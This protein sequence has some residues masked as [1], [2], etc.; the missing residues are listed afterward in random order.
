[1][2]ISSKKSNI[3]ARDKRM[4]RFLFGTLAI[5]FVLM[6]ATAYAYIDPGSAS[7][8]ITLLIGILAG[9]AMAIRTYWSRLISFFGG[10]N[11]NGP[12]SENEPKE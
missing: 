4:N 11:D 10:R 2:A 7:L 1:M 12:R 8:F 9:A 3:E 6:P 5:A